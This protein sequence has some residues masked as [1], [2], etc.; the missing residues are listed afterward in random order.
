MNSGVCKRLSSSAAGL[1]VLSLLVP[2]ASA[3]LNLPPAQQIPNMGQQ[4]TPLGQLVTLN[5]HLADNPGVLAS[6]AMSTAV[7][8]DHK[9]LL[10]LTSGYNRVYI[11]GVPAPPYPWYGP[12]SN[13]YVFVYDISKPTPVFKQAVQIPNTYNGIVFDPS[14]TH[15]YVAG[16]VNDNVHTV[17][18]A[19][20][21][22]VEELPVKLALGHHGLG[23]GL[24]IQPNGALAV[25]SQIG[26][27]PCAAGLAISTDGQTLVVANYFNDSITVFTGG[28]G[29]W[30]MTTPNLDLRPGKSAKDPQPGVPGG[31][32]PFWVVIKG[33]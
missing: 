1:L 32:Y 28:Y 16:G 9:T 25:N 30:A 7:S 5:P 31:E 17:T 21:T 20:S 14:G 19:G 4:I 29:Y 3:Q 2:L 26:V 23:I 10:V 6:Q 22:W 18:L 33:N 15:F 27:Y 12:D 24:N 8:P 13:E 11:P